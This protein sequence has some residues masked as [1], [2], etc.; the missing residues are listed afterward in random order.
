MTELNKKETIKNIMQLLDNG[1]IVYIGG[2]CLWETQ[3][4]GKTYIKWSH[5]GSSANRRTLEELTWV[6]NT[7]FEYKYKKIVYRYK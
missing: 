6:I 2:G 4:R 1:K 7:I 3:D 5:F